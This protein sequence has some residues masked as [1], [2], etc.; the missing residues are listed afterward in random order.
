MARTEVRL[1]S[2]CLSGRKLRAAPRKR[3]VSQKSVPSGQLEPWSPHVLA[4]E[5]SDTENCPPT[6]D[7][8]VIEEIADGVEKM[9]LGWSQ[10]NNQQEDPAVITTTTGGEKS[11]HGYAITASFADESSTAASKALSHAT[12]ILQRDDEVGHS[13]AAYNSSKTESSG[14]FHNSSILIQQQC[15]GSAI[16][17]KIPGE[18]ITAEISLNGNC[19]GAGMEGAI[20]EIVSTAVKNSRTMMTGDNKGS[21]KTVTKTAT[22]WYMEASNKGTGNGMQVCTEEE[23]EEEE[24]YETLGKSLNI[25]RIREESGEN[26]ITPKSAILP[27]LRI[28]TVDQGISEKPSMRLSGVLN[29]ASS[30]AP[31]AGKKLQSTQVGIK[32]KL[33]LSM[34]K[35][36]KR[37]QTTQ[38]MQPQG[39][40]PPQQTKSESSVSHPGC[41]SGQGE[42]MKSDRSEL[43]V[44]ESHG[45]SDCSGNTLLVHDS[46]HDT[47]Y[48]SCNCCAQD[49]V[50]A[51][52]TGSLGKKMAETEAIADDNALEQKM[53]SLTKSHP[54]SVMKEM[55]AGALG[56]QGSKDVEDL[57]IALLECAME[58]EI[59]TIE[60]KM[61]LKTIGSQQPSKSTQLRLE[62][63]LSSIVCSSKSSDIVLVGASESQRAEILKRQ[64]FKLQ[65]QKSALAKDVGQLKKREKFSPA[66]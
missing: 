1:R 8:N 38:V 50:K 17:A 7:Y 22:Y 25:Q 54:L 24:G 3:V 15:G 29:K 65:H 21:E 31:P 48:Q 18:S 23:E 64:M 59:K 61:R 63:G 32:P 13:G 16:A 9:I 60:M 52:E 4:D 46:R 66:V 34:S 30:P 20:G 5:R 37:L 6:L 62:S 36:T 19:Q 53:A 11:T 51:V 45:Q 12:R 33:H 44:L 2:H 35:K 10:P 39:L 49:L 41:F 26:S 28:R 55:D 57:Q 56:Q 42:S 47:S 27:N 40:L 14:S 43:Q 58:Y